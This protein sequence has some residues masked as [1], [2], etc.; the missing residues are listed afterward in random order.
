MKH[1]EMLATV[2][3]A[4]KTDPIITA[5]EI[6]GCEIKAS[7]TLYIVP[8]NTP[9]EFFARCVENDSIGVKDKIA[10]PKLKNTLLGLIQKSS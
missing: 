10:G 5:P 9:H 6:P 4:A 1:L 2:D 7:L 8:G 3:W